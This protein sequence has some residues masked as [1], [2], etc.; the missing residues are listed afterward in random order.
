MSG[1]VAELR[2]AVPAKR[3]A[4]DAHPAALSSQ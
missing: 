4:R 1:G 3:L 2:P